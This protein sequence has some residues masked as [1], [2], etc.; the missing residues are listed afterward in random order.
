[1]SYVPLYLLT[2]MFFTQLFLYC[3]LGTIA[4]LV[5]SIISKQIS[6][7]KNCSYKTCSDGSHLYVIAVNRVVL[8]AAGRTTGHGFGADQSPEAYNSFGWQH[9][10]E[11]GHIR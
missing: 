4:E 10:A 7:F 9:A 8:V 3:F 5:V 6:I 2:I 1:M 11:Y